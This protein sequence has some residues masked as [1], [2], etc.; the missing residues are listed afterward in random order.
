MLKWAGALAAVGVVGVGLGVGGDLLLRPNTVTT[1]TQ[2]S[3]STATNTQAVTATQTET[4]TQT[5]TSTVT[6]P[7]VTQTA[8]ATLTVPPT[9]LSYK[10]PLSSVVQT[11]V[12]QIIQ[13]TSAV[14][15]AD[16]IVIVNDKTNG[17][18]ATTCVLK[19]HIRNGVITL[20]EPDDS[21]IN[22]NN[23]REDIL[24]LTI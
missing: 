12:D 24:V 1:T 7:T 8:T 3:V 15:S 11:R 20:V 19:A 5:T 6:P 17:C 23:P 22:P 18:I 21:S 9:T 2:T 10:P 16:Q 13:S 14:K 4:A